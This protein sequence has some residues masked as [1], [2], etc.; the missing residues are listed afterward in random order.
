MAGCAG[1]ADISC[2][3][4]LYRIGPLP[5]IAATSQLPVA[6]VSAL[7]RHYIRAMATADATTVIDVPQPR[8]VRLDTILRLRG[9]AVLAQFSAIF[10]VS[11]GLGSDVP[12]VPCVAVVAFAGLVNIALQIVFPPMHQLAPLPAA[13]LLALH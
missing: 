8:T 6:F 1:A 12:I 7:V 2:M 9:L 13:G 3:A 5:A 10:V 4:A 11:E